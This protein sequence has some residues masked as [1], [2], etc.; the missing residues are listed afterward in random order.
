MGCMSSGQS[1]GAFQSIGNALSNGGVPA[2]GCFLRSLG[3]CWYDGS[4]H[5]QTCGNADGT[6]AGPLSAPNPPFTC[7]VVCAASTSAHIAVQLSGWHA[8]GSGRIVPHSLSVRENDIANSGLE[9]VCGCTKAG[10][11]AHS[12]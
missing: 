5:S 9:N 4:T 6:Y 3:F 8:C 2:A 10:F 11:P 1:E 12:L 7:E